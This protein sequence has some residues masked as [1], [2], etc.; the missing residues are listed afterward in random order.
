MHMKTDLLHTLA[1]IFAA[2][3]VLVGILA[4]LEPQSASDARTLSV[5]GDATRTISPDEAT[6]T[7]SVITEDADA[8]TARAEN[9]LRAEQ[10]VSILQEFGTVE[11]ASF[12]VSPVYEPWRNEERDPRIQMYRVSNTVTVTMSDLE[13]VGSAIDAG[14]TAGANQVQNVQF[15][16]TQE[17]REQVRTELLSE[18]AQNARIKADS[19][20]S[21]LDV[22]IRG[23]HSVSESSM[24]F[25]GPFYARTESMAMDAPTTPIEPRDLEVSASVQVEYSLR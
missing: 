11:T 20:A 7:F 4:V 12:F 1:I 22:R 24:S 15:S 9:A 8:N 13:R 10:L 25:P 23:V 18:A 3:I 2:G 17:T 16:L 19:L 21:S 5:S 6:I 14:S